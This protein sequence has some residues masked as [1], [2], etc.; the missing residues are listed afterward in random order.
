MKA[1]KIISIIL[2]VLGLSVIFIFSS[3][4]G[5]KSTD[6]SRSLIEITED[7]INQDV[8]KDESL[9]AKMKEE[10]KLTLK[11]NKR[12]RK[13]AHF[14]EFCILAMLIIFT[15]K[16]FGIEGYKCYTIAIIFAFIFA[17][18]DELHQFFIDG[19]D[20]RFKDV[21]I[22]TSGGALGSI[23]YASLSELFNDVKKLIKNVINK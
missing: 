23:L 19:R 20:A 12:I 11:I 14:T 17:C 2:V 16:S 22:D 10:K 9:N 3:M 18:T 1:R 4:N 5:E 13:V 6:T 15:L 7:D 8:Y 21:L